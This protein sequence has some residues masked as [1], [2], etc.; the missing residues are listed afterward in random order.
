[1]DFAYVAG[2]LTRFTGAR[3]CEGLEF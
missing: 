3:R 1:V 2:D